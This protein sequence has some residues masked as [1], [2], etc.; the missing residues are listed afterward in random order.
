[1]ANDYYSDSGAPSTGSA[2]SSATIRAEFAAIEAGFDKMAD[3]TG[4]GD[5]PVFVNSSATG[6]EAI[7]ASSART[8]LG[9]SSA[10]DTQNQTANWCGTATGTADVI[11]ATATPAITAYAAGQTFRFIS[12]GANTTNVTI[13]INSLGAKAVTKNGATALAAGDIP[14]GAVIEI[15]YDGTR[16]QFIGVVADRLTQ[17]QTPNWCG[18]AGGTADVITASVTPALTAYA[19]GQVFRFISSG[20][21]TTN[22]TININSLGAKAITKNGATALEAGDIPSGA[23]V[24]IIYDGTRFQVVGMISDR[25]GRLLNIQIITAS[26][27]YTPTAGTAKAE[28]M[29]QGGG[30]GG[31]G[32]A[33]TGAGQIAGGGGGGAGGRTL[34]LITGPTSQTVTIGAGGGGGAGVTGAT[35]GTSS[36]GAIASALGGVGGPGGIAGASG[37]GPG[38]LGGTASGGDTNIA[39]GVGSGAFG[40]TPLI[41]SGK[42]ADSAYGAGGNAVASLSSGNSAT[43]FGAGGGGAACTA[44]SG[45]AATGGTGAP[46]LIIVREYS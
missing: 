4:N 41:L 40:I 7:S 15:I 31:G 14:S 28:V 16:F 10:T 19:A 22:V 20:A 29:V 44:S 9:V 35:G 18:T 34:K 26:G 39:G 21:N 38:A 33:S 12:S 17:N 5:L 42:G 46:G 24:E 23:I 45:T 36:F 2:G 6:L 32:A 37:T 27:T 8:K 25:Q 11:T 43:G 1:M 13:N 3:L 30:G